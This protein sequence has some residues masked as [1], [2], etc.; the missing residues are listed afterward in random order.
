LINAPAINPQFNSTRAFVVAEDAA[1]GKVIA[2][3]I[4]NT[5]GGYR[6]EGLAPGSYRLLG[7]TLSGPITAADIA[8]SAELNLAA[9]SIRGSEGQTAE[10]ISTVKVAGRGRKSARCT[11]T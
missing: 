3:N 5:S 6:L 4:A 11:L 9:I 1:T 8:Q 2:G 7:E 10:Q